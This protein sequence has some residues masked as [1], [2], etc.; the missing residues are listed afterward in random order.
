MDVRPI[1]SMRRDHSPAGKVLNL[2]REK[3]NYTLKGLQGLA[4][5]SWREPAVY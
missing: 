2:L 3:R 4:N 5:I 1:T